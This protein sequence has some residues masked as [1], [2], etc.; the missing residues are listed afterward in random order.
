MTLKGAPA[1]ATSDVVV[2]PYRLVSIDATPPPNADAGDGWLIYRIAQG[3]N[4][5]TGYRRGS[6]QSV[7]EEVERIVDALNE[8]LLVRG[9]PYRSAGRPPKSATPPPTRHKDLV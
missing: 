1:S 4:V 9:R 6:R 3:T 5:I 8:R 7:G 2:E